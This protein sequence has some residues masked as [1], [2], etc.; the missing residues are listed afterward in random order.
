MAEND[1]SDINGTKHTQLVSLLE[2]TTLS[3][4]KSAVGMVRDV[5]L[6]TNGRDGRDKPK[7]R[8]RKQKKQQQ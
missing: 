8:T 4:E 7:T 3:F 2:K 5:R 1:Y 6:K